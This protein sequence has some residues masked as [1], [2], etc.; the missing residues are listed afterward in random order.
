MDQIECCFWLEEISGS[1]ECL[2][3]VYLLELIAVILQSPDTRS[4][5]VLK[6]LLMLS[7]QQLFF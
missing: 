2:A 5:S 6:I 7:I 1:I 3:W 4:L